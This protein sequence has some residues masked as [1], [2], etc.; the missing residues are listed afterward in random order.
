MNIPASRDKVESFIDNPWTKLL[1]RAA[2]FLTP[3]IVAYIGNLTLAYL[4]SRFNDQAQMTAVVSN[5]VDKLEA[6]TTATGQQIYSIQT[7]LSVVE[8][9][10]TASGDRN[11]RTQ[12][13][14]S[15]KLDGISS[16]ITTVKEKVAAIGAKVD[17]LNQKVLP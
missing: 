15:A 8:N 9:N 12:D 1:A 7:R 10:Q 3:V 14:I 2:M 4:E 13:Q 6:A 11:Q 16:D 5:R 17:T